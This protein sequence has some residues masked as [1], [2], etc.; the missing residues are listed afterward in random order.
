M[1]HIDQA[2]YLD[3][4]LNLRNNFIMFEVKTAKNKE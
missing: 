1:L 4:L 2:R 3:V